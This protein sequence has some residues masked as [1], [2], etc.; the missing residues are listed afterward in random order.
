MTEII[1]PPKQIPM[2]SNRKSV[3]LAGT[4]D[5][6]NSEDW[7]TKACEILKPYDLRIYNPRRDSWEGTWE[8]NIDTN[9][10]LKNQ[11]N[12]ELEALEESDF[13]VMNLLPESKS[14]I[15][16]LELGM[17][18]KSG[19]LFISC[20]KDFYRYANI[21]SVCRMFQIPL[22]NNLS[23]LLNSLIKNNLK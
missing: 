1:R 8:Q 12:W 14:P 17:Y 11:I 15:S 18:A 19:K 7:Q 13:I 6:G 20:P 2:I 9:T 23:D 16:L 5:N 3:F 21:Q 10:E 4:I 22:F